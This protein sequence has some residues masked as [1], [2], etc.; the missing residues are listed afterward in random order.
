MDTKLKPYRV[1][2]RADLTAGWVL[3]GS[4]DENETARTEAADARKKWRGQTRVISQHVIEV[5]GPL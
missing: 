5:E 2:W 1:E 4:Y 3:I